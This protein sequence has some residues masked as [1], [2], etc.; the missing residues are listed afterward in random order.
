MGYTVGTGVATALMNVQWPTAHLP[1][2]LTAFGFTGLFQRTDITTVQWRRCNSCTC[3]AT[4]A[5]AFQ[6]K[7][8]NVW[9]GKINSENNMEDD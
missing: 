9:F 4:G 5:E 8:K 3:N 2:N 1:S 6:L 7:N